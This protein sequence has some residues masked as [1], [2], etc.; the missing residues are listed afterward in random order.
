MNAI[1]IVPLCIFML[2]VAYFATN[3]PLLPGKMAE[4][5][6]KFITFLVIAVLIFQ[7]GVYCANLIRFL[8]VG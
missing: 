4:W 1:A 2:F 5:I 6:W 7:I 3:N 8:K